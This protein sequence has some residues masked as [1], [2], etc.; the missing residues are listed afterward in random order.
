MESSRTRI[1]YYSVLCPAWF[2]SHGRYLIYEGQIYA[3][4]NTCSVSLASDIKS[5]FYI[6]LMVLLKNKTDIYQSPIMA[7]SL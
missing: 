4:M 1:L 3:E 5:A 2:K 7:G 6:A